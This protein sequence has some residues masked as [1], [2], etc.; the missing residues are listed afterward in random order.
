MH[1]FAHFAHVCTRCYD[2]QFSRYS[3]RFQHFACKSRAKMF[4]FMSFDLYFGVQTRAK[5]FAHVWSGPHPAPGPPARAASSP[6]PN[7]AWAMS[8]M[9]GFTNNSHQN[10]ARSHGRDFMRGITCIHKNT[11]APFV[12]CTRHFLERWISHVLKWIQQVSG[13]KKWQAP[14]F[15]VRV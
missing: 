5:H 6:T 9:A 11:G 7:Q 3:H 4:I 1:T 14:F 8:W 13:T 12:K 15:Q 10:I 2:T